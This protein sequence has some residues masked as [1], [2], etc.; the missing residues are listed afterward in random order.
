MFW[1]KRQDWKASHIRRVCLEAQVF[2][3]KWGKILYVQN[4]YMVS[5]LGGGFMLL[6]QNGFEQNGSKHFL[7]SIPYLWK[8]S[9][10]TCAKF[11][12]MGW[13]NHQLRYL[14]LVQKKIFGGQSSR[15]EMKKWLAWCGPGVWVNRTWTTS[16]KRAFQDWLS[17]WRKVCV[18]W[19]YRYMDVMGKEIG[20]RWVCFRWSLFWKIYA[21]EYVYIYTL[22]IYMGCIQLQH[23]GFVWLVILYF[24]PW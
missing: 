20:A 18:S 13:F 8:R 5:I 1:R 14:F 11:F 15:P 19:L 21:Y 22:Y 10:L 23:N 12:N 9:N 17:A 4:T 16:P 6:S 7:I 24:L 3:R 2:L